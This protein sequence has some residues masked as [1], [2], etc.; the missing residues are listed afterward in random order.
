MIIF[1]FQILIPKNESSLAYIAMKL[2][3]D[4]ND[5]VLKGSY[6]SSLAMTESKILIRSFI[7]IRIAL[8]R[9]FDSLK[10]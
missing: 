5:P 10:S 9:T 4:H 3:G 6:S 7:G 8:F 1:D 2:E